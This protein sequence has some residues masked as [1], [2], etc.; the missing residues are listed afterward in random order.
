MF[1]KENLLEGEEGRE[2]SE[3]ISRRCDIRV[4]SSSLPLRGHKE[5]VELFLVDFGIGDPDYK[6]IV[7]GNLDSVW[8][9]APD[10]SSVCLGIKAKSANLWHACRSLFGKDPA[11]GN[12]VEDC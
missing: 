4:C 9:G 5:V 11:L 10:W 8:I 3:K 12:R 7:V 6:M 2:K 1:G